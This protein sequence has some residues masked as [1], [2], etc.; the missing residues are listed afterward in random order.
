VELR[1]FRYFVAVAEELHF[2]RAAERLHIGQPPL[3]LQIQSIERELGVTL[4]NRNRRKVELTEAGKLFLVEARA[5]LAQAARAVETA[6]RAARG[7]VG[8]LRVSFTTSA[9]LTRVFTRTVRAFREALPAVHLELRIQISQQILD[10]L[11]LDSIDVGLIRPAASH[12]IPSGLTSIPLVRDRLLLVLPA[13]HALTRWKGRVPLKA[14]AGEH[15]VLRQRGSGAGYYEQV[16]QICAQAGFA[17][18]V[19]QEATEPPTLLGMVAAGFGVTIMPASL[20]AIQ[21][22]DVVWRELDLGQ[23]AVSSILLVMNARQENSLR[24]QFV[25]IMKRNIEPEKGVDITKRKIKRTLR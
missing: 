16:L 3:S 13:A 15:F 21:V 12:P 11:L 17:P 6:K 14:L 19:V 20:Q 1:Q 23:E 9:P 8:N 10:G 5:A 24:D 4:L 2:S 18:N 25:E 7:E 22:E